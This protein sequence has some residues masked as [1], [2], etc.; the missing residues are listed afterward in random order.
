MK[1]LVEALTGLLALEEARMSSG[2][3]RPNAAGL[4]LIERA[5]KSLQAHGVDPDEERGRPGDPVSPDDEE[6]G[7]AEHRG[8]RGEA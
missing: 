8:A 2:A 4:A 6:F 1:D 5:R 3:F 7:M